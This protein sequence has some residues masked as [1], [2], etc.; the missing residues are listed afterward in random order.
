MK[1]LYVRIVL[2]TILIVLGSGVLSFLLCN[3][4]YQGQLKQYNEQKLM[5]IATDVVQ[6]YE[7]FPAIDL[8]EYLTGVADLNYQLYLVDATGEGTMF[9]APFKEMELDPSIVPSVLAGKP[10]PGVMES[11]H[12]PFITGFFENT[13]ANSIG[14]PLHANGTTYALFLRPNIEGM[15]GEVRILLAM[16]LVLTFVISLLFLVIFTRFIVSPIKRLTAATQQIAEGEFDI[17]LEV[18]RGD[19]IG[20]LAKH[21]SKMASELKKLEEMRQEFVSNVSHEIQSPLTSIQGFSQALRTEEMSLEERDAHLAIIEEESRRLSSLSQQLL[22]LSALDKGGALVRKTSFRLD[23][24]I[25][26]VVLMLEWQWREKN[27]QLDLQ[28]PK[29]TLDADSNFLHLVWVNLLTNAIKFTP[30]GGTI[31][32][33][34]EDDGFEVKATVADDGIGI[35]PHQLARVFERF[36]IA[37]PSRDRTERSGSGL[38]LAI[39]KKIISLHRGTIEV[40][41][42]L[43][44]GTAFTIILPR[45]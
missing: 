17:D 10:Y 4:Y 32:L 1:T 24:Q 2:M 19:E 34:L 8:H 22:T 25:R 29:V 23:E 30:E 38:G 6:K 18:A 11:Q 41:S 42:E 39:V 13:L 16:L 28:L 9:G 36:Y 12:G 44:V 37:D 14:V 15:L 21:F 31:A 20:E 43:G 7:Q 5:G 45:L 3:F 27:L 35:A 26:E 40:K 33:Q